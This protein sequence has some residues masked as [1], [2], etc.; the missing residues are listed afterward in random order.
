MFVAVRESD[1]DGAG[2]CREIGRGARGGGRGPVVG[3]RDSLH[4]A[5][6]LA[7]AD[8]KISARVSGSDL[9]DIR[10]HDGETGPTARGW[11]AR[12]GDCIRVEGDAESRATFARPG[13]ASSPGAGESSARAPE[14]YKVERA[15]ARKVSAP[16]RR[17]F[18]LD[19]CSPAPGG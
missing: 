14:K 11:N 18:A 15:G 2:R 5:L 19:H 10:G 12:P 9:R 6:H 13:I 1:F 4:R 7:E 16:A 17:A 3:R 8:R